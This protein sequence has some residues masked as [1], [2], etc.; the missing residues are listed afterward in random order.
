M[1]TALGLALPGDATG[2]LCLFAEDVAGNTHSQAVAIATDNAAPVLTV[3]PA[4]DVADA[5]KR[6]HSFSATITDADSDDPL[7]LA[8]EATD[9][10]AEC[11]EFGF[12][13]DGSDRRL[14]YGFWA[15][16]P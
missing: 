9:T 4:D 15:D 11:E 13:V 1:S 2:K 3:D 10:A 8:Y 7:S 5:W 12:A 14:P 6:S 16:N